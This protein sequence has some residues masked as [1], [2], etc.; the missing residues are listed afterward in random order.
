MPLK[1]ASLLKLA[2][3]CHMRTIA[4]CLLL[5]SVAVAD[6]PLFSHWY[7]DQLGMGHTLEWQDQ[8]IQA[9]LPI[10]PSVRDM[11]PALGT[12]T[13]RLNTIDKPFLERLNGRNIAFRTNNITGDMIARLPAVTVTEETWRGSYLCVRR[14]VDGSLELTPLGALT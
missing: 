9:G 14:K 11:P 7:A 1:I 5:C 8:Q 2:A 4:A 6:G 3:G 13:S 10:E 12:A